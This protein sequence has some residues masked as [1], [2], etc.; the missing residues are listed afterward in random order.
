[1]LMG[2][3]VNAVLIIAGGLMGILFQKG[4]PEKVNRTLTQGLGLCVLY[5]GI[6]GTL[7][8][9]NIIVVI[10][11]VVIGAVIGELLDFEKRLQW[12]GD[13]LQARM[14]FG[15]SNSTFAEG[16]VTCTLIYCVGAMAIV[17]SLQS[18]LSGNHE[19]LYAKSLLDGVMSLVMSSTLGIGVAFSAV[20]VLLYEALLTVSAHA[21]AGVLTTPVINE[22]TCVGSLLI[23]AIA[24]NLLKLTNIKVSNFILAPFLPIALLYLF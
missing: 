12:M 4:V 17:G 20:P 14:K 1:M 21:I 3:M 6:S 19:T 22:M 9:E 11:S 24:L 16:F 15:G 23:V 18:G 2:A 5:V 8:G 7:K 10:L 13:W